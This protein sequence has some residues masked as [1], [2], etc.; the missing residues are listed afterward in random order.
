MA[1]VEKLVARLEAQ[2]RDFERQLARAASTTDRR[3]RQIEN[4]FK[5]TNVEVTRQ[6]RSMGTNIAG[7][8]GGLTGIGLGGIG[9]AGIARGVR[10]AVS[11]LSELGKTARTVSIDVEELQGLM[12]G[13]E[14]QTNVTG[15]QA[16]QAFERFA[17]RIGEAANGTGPLA[18]TLE[19]IN[20]SVRDGNGAIRTQ[21]DLLR[22]VADRIRDASSDAERLAIAQA[23]FGDVGRQMVE[24]LRSGGSALDAMV[25]E[26]RAA[27]DVIE[28]DL[29]HRAE[30]L[31]DAFDRLTRR[32]GTFFKA[33]AVSAAGG[34]VQT[35][36]D[37]MREIFGDLERARQVLGDDLFA[38]LTGELGRIGAG[39]QGVADSFDEMRAA[40]REAV[41]EA[42]TL[43]IQL[44]D[45]D[46]IDLGNQVLAMVDALV[47]AQIAFQDNEM[48]AEDLSAAITEAGREVESLVRGIEG[49]DAATLSG[50]IG[51]FASLA[52]AAMQAAGAVRAVREEVDPGAF[53][54]GINRPGPNTVRPRS[55]PID[56]DFGVPPARGGGGGGGGRARPDDFQRAAASIRERTEALELEAVAL[57]TA[58]QAGGSYAEALDYARMRSDLLSAAQREGIA[59]TAETEAVVDQMARA[60]ADASARLREVAD[61]QQEAEERARELQSSFKEA[62]VAFVTGAG[63][64]RDAARQL[65]Q[66]LA[67]LAANRAFEAIAGALF[68]GFGGGKSIGK[69]ASGGSVRAGSPYLVNE[70]TPNS[71]VFVPSRSGAILNV[72]QAQAALRGGAGGVVRILVDE[73]PMF[74][75]RVRTEAQG[76]A[77]S[78]TRAGI[79]GFSREALPSRVAQLSRD[80]RRRG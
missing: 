78:V 30:L 23:A 44:Y 3:A 55:R 43:A 6:F 59:V 26:A 71:E 10:S 58:A 52:S 68:G 27:G 12:R 39:V 34:G 33:L 51:R 32:V 72:P 13:F 80:P 61:A 4:R 20:V 47:D 75:S 49:V 17:R 56:I 16:S 76:V 25:R 37:Q 60:Y 79:E 77:V 28:R 14:R 36:L 62:F 63:E 38:E 48:S 24:A 18:T 65:L 41:A 73:G 40:L 29:I 45:L 53:E 21:S 7:V 50:I 9:A 70:N 46:E 8:L 1:E 31:D 66:S 74:A 64:A 57:M 15:A 67:R 19:R 11:E 35:P 5:R 2:H 69:R 42:D 54:G 22:E